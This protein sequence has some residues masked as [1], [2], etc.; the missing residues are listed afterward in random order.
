MPDLTLNSYKFLFFVVIV[1]QCYEGSFT[2]ETFLTVIR[3]SELSEEL[4]AVRDKVEEDIS[5]WRSKDT[6]GSEGELRHVTLLSFLLGHL[7]LAL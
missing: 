1:R 2:R 6:G 7:S 4:E 3:S 5:R